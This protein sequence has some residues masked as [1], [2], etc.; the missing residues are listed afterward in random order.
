MITRRTFLLTPAVLAACGRRRGSG[1]DGYAFV[2]AQ[3]GRAVAAVDLIA[4]AVAR[5]IRLDAGPTAIVADPLRP[6]VYA[7]TA[8]TGAVHEIGADTLALRRSL[9]AAR[10]AVS[11]RISPDGHFLWLLANQPR[12]LLRLSTENLRVE[13]RI[14][15]PAEPVD[16]DLSPNGELAAVSFGAAGAVGIVN[17]SRGTCSWTGLGKNLSLVRFRSDGRQ[18]LAGNTEDRALT[19]L[20]VPAG[21][22]IVNLPL[23]VRPDH[24]CFGASQG[25]LFITG[26]GM[27]SVVIVYPYL[28]EVA[29]TILAGKSPGAMAEAVGENFDF[30][31]VANAQ[32]N[33]VTIID[34]ETHRVVAVVAVGQEPGAITITPDGQY[35]LVLNRVSGDMAVIRLGAITATRSRSAPLFTMIPVGSKPVGAVVRGV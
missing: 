3:E 1:F 34:I 18:L 30:L 35:A 20:D 13:S 21:R 19:I 25:Q 16:F 32:S 4:F 26:E 14:A 11:M 27:D 8:E 10:T 24:F 9:R 17:L 2:A 15:L 33:E 22:V 5:H 7:L 31:L 29:E 23:V 12:Q 28:T 6:S